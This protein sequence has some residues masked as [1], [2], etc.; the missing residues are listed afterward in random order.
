MNLSLEEIVKGTGGKLLSGNFQIIVS[1]IST[2][3]RCLQKGDFYV[4]LKGPRFDGHDF[5]EEAVRKGASALLVSGAPAGA[6]KIPIVIVSD[7]LRALGDIALCW[8]QKFSLPVVAITGSNGKTSTKEM[9]ASVLSL[10]AD[11]VK[12]EGNLNNL[13]GLPLTLFDLEEKQRFCILEMGMNDFG[14]IARLTEIA[15]PTIG[16][17]TNVGPAHLEKL[18]SLEGVAKA[19]EELFQGL[20]DKAWGVVNQDDPFIVKMRTKAKKITFG[21]SKKADIRMEKI[22]Y[23]SDAMRMRI[24]HPGGL[25]VFDLPVVGEHHARNGLASYAVLN[26]LGV[27]EEKIQRG[28]SHYKVQR[29]RGEE[30]KLS[31]GIVVINDAYNANPASMTVALKNLNVKHPDKRKIAVLG[32]MFELGAQEKTLHHELG[33]LAAESGVDTLLAYGG[34]AIRVAQGF[35]EKKKGSGFGFDS[36]E[37]LE[38]R[39]DEILKKGDVVLVKG[40]RGARMERIVEHLVQN[41]KLKI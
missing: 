10:E 2:D 19:K 41:L 20:D 17:I 32:D 13:I 35:N 9:M 6:G 11:I 18:D 4:A 34:N 3:T 23:F 16:L 12:T 40:S 33:K 38:E 27:S 1:K 39:L 5:V 25:S 28:F 24:R 29:M 36:L 8:R 15:R 14:E 37:T 30:F 31:N 26:L 21:F 7:T 22:D